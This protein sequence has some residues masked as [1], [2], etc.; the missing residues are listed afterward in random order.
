MILDSYS[1][2][3]VFVFLLTSLVPIILPLA[4]FYE[5]QA[6]TKNKLR[7]YEY[8]NKASRLFNRAILV[9]LVP[10]MTYL[11]YP[12][13]RSDLGVEY[14]FLLLIIYPFSYFFSLLIQAFFYRK[15]EKQIEEATPEITLPYV[16]KRAISL[17]MPVIGI[18][19]VVMIFKSLA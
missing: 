6:A 18:V 1:F 12:N 16:F 19:T 3:Q 4:V 15:L 5:Y 13:I 14:T 8:E 11:I 7:F 17:L 10:L 9:F 2:G